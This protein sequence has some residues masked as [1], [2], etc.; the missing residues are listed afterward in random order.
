MPKGNIICAASCRHTGRG[1][2]E[3]PYGGYRQRN[4]LSPP[5]DAFEGTS[6][7][8]WASLLERNLCDAQE[9]VVV[10]GG[11]SPGQAV[12]YLAAKVAK[13]WLIVRGPGLEAS[14]SSYL[15]E[16]IAARNGNWKSGW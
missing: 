6:V 12:V 13:L 8:Y 15:I 9:V 14:M 1:A 5:L 3:R 16:R 4:P 11:N 2:T 7:H 10:G